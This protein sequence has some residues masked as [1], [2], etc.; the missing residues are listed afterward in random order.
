MFNYASDRPFG[1][2]FAMFIALAFTSRYFIAGVEKGAH[3]FADV[4]DYF[5]SLHELNATVV[6]SLHVTRNHI[7]NNYM[8]QETIFKT[9]VLAT[10]IS[11]TLMPFQIWASFRK[12]NFQR[13]RTLGRV[14]LLLLAIGMMA[15][16]FIAR[17]VREVEEGGGMTSEFGF[18][19]TEIIMHNAFERVNCRLLQTDSLLFFVFQEWQFQPAFVLSW[20]WLESS[21]VMWRTTADGWSECMARSGEASS[22]FESH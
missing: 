1:Q 2:M 18:Y 3:T 12:S 5:F 22:G 4:Q 19:G 7:V 13:H 11:W 9:H 14:S 20:A 15:S 10:G 16:V 21:R 17:P 6:P 8:S